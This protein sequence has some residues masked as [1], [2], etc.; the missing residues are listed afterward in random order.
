M[1]QD[2][3]RAKTGLPLDF[4]WL[5]GAEQ[6]LKPTVWCCQ[7]GKN[8]V[9][10]PRFGAVRLTIVSIKLLVQT[11]S[12]R[13]TNGATQREQRLSLAK[14]RVFIIHPLY[15]STQPALTEFNPTV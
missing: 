4:E 13:S 7:T 2:L 6:S 9:L 8:N 15:K 11:R 14:S 10:K 1:H 3:I 12:M 5:E